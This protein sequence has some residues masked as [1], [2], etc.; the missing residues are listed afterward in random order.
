MFVSWSVLSQRF[1]EG[2]NMSSSK[3]SR[4]KAVS[5]VNK[6]KDGSIKKDYLPNHGNDF[7]G[8]YEQYYFDKFHVYLSSVTRFK[9]LSRVNEGGYCGDI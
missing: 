3:K 5:F 4:E 2:D 6:L 8:G 7:H 1:T 9:H